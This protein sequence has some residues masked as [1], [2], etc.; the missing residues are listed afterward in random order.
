[1]YANENTKSPL[2]LKN[3]DLNFKSF[4]VFHLPFG[5]FFF[6]QSEMHFLA[7]SNCQ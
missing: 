6:C 7:L 4:I 3:E 2:S 5:K 1:M